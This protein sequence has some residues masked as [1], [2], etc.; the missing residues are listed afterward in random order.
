MRDAA[1]DGLDRTAAREA[2][3]W[4]DDYVR[5]RGGRALSSEIKAEGR[6]AGHTESSLKSARKRLGLL[7]E[8]EGFPR[9]T[10]WGLASG[11]RDEL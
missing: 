3:G 5:S 9:Q 4:L 6:K 10:F 2:M 8:S 11:E 1:D 7:I